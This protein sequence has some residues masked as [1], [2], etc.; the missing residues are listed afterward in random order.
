MS[1]FSLEDFNSLLISSPACHSLLALLIPSWQQGSQFKFGEQGA[2][3][4]PNLHFSQHKA[5]HERLEEEQSR[6]AHDL[7]IAQKQWDTKAEELKK[8]TDAAL[9]VER[10]SKSAA[11]RLTKANTHVQNLGMRLMPSM[12]RSMNYKWSMIMLNL[13]F[14]LILQLPLQGSIFNISHFCISLQPPPFIITASWSWFSSA[15]CPVVTNHAGLCHT[16]HPSRFCDTF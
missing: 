15:Y 13:W 16:S 6:I 7:S 11:T 5:Q 12:Q 1:K 3:W 8:V 10:Q 2:T 9:K 4:V 14:P